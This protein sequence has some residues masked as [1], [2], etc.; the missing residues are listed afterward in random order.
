M[1]NITPQEPGPISQVRPG[2]RVIDHDGDEVGRV[3]D[4]KLGDPQAITPHGQ[5][6]DHGESLIGNLAEALGGGRDPN[7]PDQLAARLLRTGYIK[8]DSKGVL[9]RDLYAGPD[10]I[11]SVHGDDVILAVPRSQLTAGA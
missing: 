5:T 4:V 2:M 1:T 11:G 8:I 7:V 6:R 3:D 9:A 10:T